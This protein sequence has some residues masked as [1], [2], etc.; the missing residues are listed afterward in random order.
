MPLNAPDATGSI[1]DAA[2]EF[3]SSTLR[4]AG[5][6]LDPVDGDRLADLRANLVVTPNTDTAVTAYLNSQPAQAAHSDP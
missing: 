2:R 6:V 5:T 4:G 1:G 3:G